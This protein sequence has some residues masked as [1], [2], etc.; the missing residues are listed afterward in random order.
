MTQRAYDR[1]FITS[2][3]Y[4]AVVLAVRNAMP[5]PMKSQPHITLRYAKAIPVL[6]TACDIEGSA[7][8][9]FEARVRQLQ[10]LGVPASDG[11]R[12]AGPLGYGIVELAALAT[13][14]KL[15]AAFMVP[16]LAARYVTERWETLAPALLA[17]ARAVLPAS[18]LARRP[19]GDET[20]ILIEASA[21]AELG[22]QGQH[23]ERYA[24]ALGAAVKVSAVTLIDTLQEMGGT[25]AILDTTG[26]MSAIVKGFSWETMAG[27]EELA[28]ELD[29][30]RFS[31]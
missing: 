27:E 19:L 1:M 15:M 14:I 24:G 7:R 23:G 9:A 30:L 8:S 6:M 22:G 10:R 3:V 31:A 29:R 20:I 2:T 16:T 5:V 11:A 17:G 28:H 12:P 21:L 4:V 25:G 13:A 18:Y 26:Y